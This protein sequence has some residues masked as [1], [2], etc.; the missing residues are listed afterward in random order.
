MTDRK[1]AP[2]PGFQGQAQVEIA[3]ARYA[4]ALAIR[5]IERGKL[6]DAAMQAVMAAKLLVT[7][8]ERESGDG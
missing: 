7:A 1:G 5:L 6:N 2:A 4:L 3:A 8:D